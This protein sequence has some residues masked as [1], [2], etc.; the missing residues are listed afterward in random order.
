MHSTHWEVKGIRG[1]C[2]ALTG[3]S[4]GL[5]GGAQ[6][7][8]EVKGIRGRFTELTGDLGGGPQVKERLALTGRSRRDGTGIT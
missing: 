5:G 2:T 4:R 7:Y 3:R 1:R 6:H 8:W